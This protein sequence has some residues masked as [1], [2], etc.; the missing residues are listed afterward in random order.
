GKTAF[1]RLMNG[2]GGI[3]VYD[4]ICGNIYQDIFGQSVFAGKGL[5]DID[6]F[7]Q[8]LKYAFPDET[9]LSHDILEGGF[10]RCGFLS[11][12][13][14]T[15]GCPSNFNG[16][17]KRLHRWIRGDFQNIKW[18]FGRIPV[19]NGT[20]DNPLPYAQKFFIT[21]NVVRER[22]AASPLFLFFSCMIKPEFAWLF[23]TA[24]VLSAF[25]ANLYSASKSLFVGGFQMLSRKYY[26][27]VA[28]DTL[29]ELK[30][31]V[32]SVLTSFYT[33]CLIVD[34]LARGLFRVFISKKHLLEWV[35]AADFENNKDPDLL[36]TVFNQGICVIAAA[37]LFIFGNMPMIIY[38]LII[39]SSPFVSFYVSRKKIR[40][41]IEIGE[42]ERTKLL[43]YAAESWRY[44]AENCT[45]DENWL[46]P[47]NIQE[48]PVKSVAHRTSPTNIGL[49]LLSVL[50]ASD[51]GFIDMEETVKRVED[52]LT[53]VEKLEKYHGNLLNWYDTQSLA[54]LQPKYCS[55]VD[56]GNFLCCIHALKNGLT[57]KGV[58]PELIK[59]IDRIENSADLAVLYDNER[60]LFHIG[61]DLSKKQLS[62]S[63]Y[64][65][66]MSEARATSYYAIAKCRIDKKHWGKLGRTLAK[67]D[68]YTGSVSWTGTMFEY[69]MPQIFLPVYKDTL[70]YEALRFC[71][72]CQRKRGIKLSKPWGCS[73]SAYYAFDNQLNYQYKAH[74]I[75]K[76]GL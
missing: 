16:W 43:S 62:E 54:T 75:Q 45:E 55:T 50:A 42:K 30:K 13:E 33:S 56:S 6:V 70:S 32:F 63:Y 38:G 28:T 58:S 5:I 67:L 36:Q 49:Y 14:I 2:T 47:D 19:K 29:H 21:D 22:A 68:N 46:P 26:S 64:D 9:V 11:D 18:I 17:S 51:F 52:T 23:V 48:S 7:Y 10:L 44:Y 35:T 69:F 41:P 59:R 31:G 53:T 1:S 27:D 4:T 20:E 72:Y 60:K 24:A 71:L 57:V 8:V 73:E 65:L 34:A 61:Y 39:I 15:D 40:N 66:L 76:L 74:G 12:I 37:L 25:S 3:T